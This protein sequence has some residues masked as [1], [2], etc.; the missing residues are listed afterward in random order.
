MIGTTILNRYNIETELGRGGMGVVFTA[1][2]TLLNRVVAIK[3]LNASG[4]GTEG[5]AR[6]LQEARAAARLN[7]PN[8]VSVYDAA[9]T[10]G[11]PF[12]VMELVK[13][14]TLRNSEKLDLLD[15]LHMT[16][17]IC[18]ALEHAHANGIIHRDLKL[19]NIVITNT[20]NLKLMDFGLAHSI[21]DAHITEEGTLTGTLAYLAPE[22]IQGQPASVKSDLYAFGI[23][24][25][26]L[27]VGRAPFQGT[28]SAV[29]AQHM[30]GKVIPPSEHNAGIPIWVDD[31]VLRLL[32]KH[33]EDRP[34]SARDVLLILEQKSSSPATTSLFSISSK[35]KNNLPIQLTAFIGR[36]KEIEE[37]IESIKNH[38]LVTLTGSG[39]TGKTRLSLQ[40]AENL[41]DQFEYFW[42]VELA[43]ISDPANI[44]QAILSAMGISEQQGKS[45]QELIN[46]YLQDKN[47]LIVLDNCE[48]LIEASAKIS[49]ALLNHAPALKILASSREALG[50][51]GEMAW[52]VPSL[53]VPDI[54][55]LPEF[56]ELSQYE[57]IRLFVERATLAKPNFTAT[58]ENAA[59][60][61]Q[62]CSRLDGIPLAIELAASRV[63][64]LSVDQIAAR[65]DDRFR[66]LTGGSRTSLPRQQTLRATIDWS[67][68]LLTEE[69]KT[70]LRG[71]TVFSGGW[72]LEAAESVCIQE[73]SEFDI[74]NLL[75]RLVDKSLVNLKDSRYRILET[76][77][78]Y[79]LEKLAES[80]EVDAVRD[81]HLDYYLKLTERAEPKLRSAQ[82][83]IW[84]NRLEAEHDNLRTALE[85]SLGRDDAEISLR[86]TGAGWFFWGMRGYSKDGSRW[87]KAALE[88]PGAEKRGA[89][90]AKALTGLAYMARYQ[91]DLLA[92]QGAAQEAVDIWR[93]VGDKW[94]LAFTLGR[95]GGNLLI[96]GD[97]IGARRIQEEAVKLAREAEDKWA[98][99][100]VLGNLGRVLKNSGDYQTAR[101]VQEEGLAV[102]RSVGDKSC[103]AEALE[104]LGTLAH[105][106]GDDEQAVVLY[107]ES[108]EIYR[109][110]H[111]VGGLLS[112]LFESGCIIQ[113]QG[114]NEQ[115]ATLFTEA[116]VLAQEADDKNILA[117]ALAGLGGVAGAK[118][119]PEQAA[120]LLGA[121]EAIFNALGVEI[122]SLSHHRLVDY[123]GWVANV[124]SQLD[125]A[126]FKAVWIEG[127]AMTLEQSIEYALEVDYE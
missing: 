95:V 97:L 17:Q 76:V 115:A 106:Q 70:L 51:K 8:I 35:S 22:L 9:E 92:S 111:Y 113:S 33:P 112:L 11:L 69:E 56:D 102:Y 67:Y 75:S 96:Q 7:H 81:R 87:L 117:Q 100:D 46:E 47:T 103:I 42:F 93:E 68:N 16:Q 5:K 64:A 90:R 58:K 101:S 119:R 94:W 59:F 44:P 124:R 23:I 36:E 62:V 54:N 32:S 65:L 37:V 123:K 107:K 120:L 13:G 52:H 80:G 27:L 98:L 49:Y 114:D 2:D 45:A 55:H 10:N 108:L 84:L 86:F 88:K 89:A 125:E 74:L 31:L 21:D 72:T 121:S 4:V 71:L 39:G 109:E 127:R 48:H 61:A 29:L 63:K 14:V 85:W 77:R 53:S 104:A 43:P 3:F 82:Q 19:E 78:Q 6:L 66:L 122:F 24:L 105:I 15:V 40:V 12:I 116:L 91:S 99:G 18:L 28:V 25:Y 126:T 73:G 83:L 20:Q 26:E 34:V 118:G 110:L 41:L 1:H 30:Q 57:S 50:V 38:R 79:A 60:I